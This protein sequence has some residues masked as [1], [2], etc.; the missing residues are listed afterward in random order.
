MKDGDQVSND[1][2]FK[3][4]IRDFLGDLLELVDPELAAELD[5]SAPQFQSPEVFKD[6]QKHGHQVPDLVARVSTREGKPRT[7]LVHVEVEGRFRRETGGTGNGELIPDVG[8]AQ[9]LGLS[10]PQAE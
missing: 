5:L 7:V 9:A 4:A 8:S 3:T 10:P 6:F 2:L 1:K